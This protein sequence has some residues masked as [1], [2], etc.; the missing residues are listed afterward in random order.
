MNS[1]LRRCA[2]PLMLLLTA[3]SSAPVVAPAPPP[4]PRPP[5]KIALV[6]GGGAARGFAHIGV[7]KMLDALEIKPD[8]IVGT[9]AGSV[10]GALYAA[11]YDGFRLQEMAF[12]LDQSMVADWSVFGKGLIKGQ[13]LE[14]YV[15]RAVGNKGIEQLKKP[16]ACVATQLRTGQPILF[17]RGNVGTAVRASSSVPGIFEPVLI[18]GE[19][20]VDGGLVSPVPVK[21]ARQLG[22]DFIIAV[23]VSSPP[24]R[25]E[26]DS[27]IAVLLKTFTIM[28]QSIRDAEITQADVV[29]TPK[30]DQ[31][32]STDFESKHK[33]ILAGERAA[34]AAIPQ[35]RE[36]LRARMDPA[37]AALPP[38][39]AVP[40]PA[41]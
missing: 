9:S 21:Y 22:A 19:E 31:I 11:G 6:L 3:C 24:G 15:N 14:D 41:H 36:K 4:A 5:P 28:G 39:D 32:A 13:A 34:L 30:L 1:A 12:D 29:I 33:A 38:A 27:K 23:D 35:I 8:L 40:A 20:Y 10:A 37:P 18:N 26:A 16:F 7:I 17:Q 2:I 25:E